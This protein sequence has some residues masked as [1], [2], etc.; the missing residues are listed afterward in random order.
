MRD[1]FEEFVFVH[2]NVDSLTTSFLPLYI[3]YRQVFCHWSYNV[4]IELSELNIEVC[5][6]F[7]VTTVFTR[8][9]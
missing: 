7:R 5:C 9:R 1:I 4:H 6:V 8:W 2:D 3:N